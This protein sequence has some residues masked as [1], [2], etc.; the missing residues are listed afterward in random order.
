MNRGRGALR[1][2]MGRLHETGGETI[3]ERRNNVKKVG[4]QSWG[5]QREVTCAA[6][7]LLVTSMTAHRR[8]PLPQTTTICSPPNIRDTQNCSIIIVYHFGAKRGYSHIHIDR[9]KKKKHVQA[10]LN[11]RTQMSHFNL[12]Y[13]ASSVQPKGRSVVFATHKIS[14]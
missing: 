3:N 6:I 14:K 11:V 5:S 7:K 4:P 9:P 12:R 2:T 10:E 1:E 13:R 8:S